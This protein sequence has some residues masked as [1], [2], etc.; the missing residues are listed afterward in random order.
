V[1]GA[2]AESLLRNAEAALKQAKTGGDRYRF[3]TRG[4]TD[5]VAG[6]LTLENQLRRA[7][8]DEEFILHYQPKID[9]ASGKLTG[10]EA[11]I[12]WNDPDTGLVPPGRFIPVLEES[13]LIHEVGRWAMRKALEDYL[14]GTP[15][16]C[17][18]CA[19]P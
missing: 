12:R 3:Y 15:R 2:D 8:D 4:M 13:G 9:L 17:R 6:K 16:A 11:L 10:A 7:L 5:A 14:R 18:W 1:D 19:F